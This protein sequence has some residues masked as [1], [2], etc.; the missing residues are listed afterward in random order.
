MNTSTD[1]GVKI[2]PFHTIFNEWYAAQTSKKVR[3]VWKTKTEH[4]L[5]VSHHV[6]FGYVRD[7]EDKEKWLIDEEAAKVVKRFFT[8]IRGVITSS[9]AEN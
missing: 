8:E 7:K 4:K 2:M 6:P 3:Q 9:F 5:R 1:E